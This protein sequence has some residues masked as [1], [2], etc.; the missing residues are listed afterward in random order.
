M[1]IININ[2]YSFLF[3][4]HLCCIDIVE[5][6]LENKEARDTDGH[7]LIYMIC[8]LVGVVL[9]RMGPNCL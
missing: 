3:P 1:L 8:H 7:D 6:H 4:V 2:A 5:Y 9:Q